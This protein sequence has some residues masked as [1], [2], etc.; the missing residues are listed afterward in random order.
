MIRLICV[1][2]LLGLS[3]AASEPVRS[4]RATAEWLAESPIV[5]PGQVLR[6]VVRLVID[7]QWHIYWRNPG[8]AG[9]PTSA[10]WTLPDGW[11]A[12]EFSHPVP[13]SF[14]TG[15]LA[16]YGYEGTALFPV[17]L[18]VPMGMKGETTLKATVSWLACQDDACVPGEAQLS[19]QVRA[20]HPSPTPVAPDIERAFADKPARAP[21]GMRLDVRSDGKDLAL[22]VTGNPPIDVSSATVYA[23]S[24]DTLDPA[25]IIR[26]QKSGDSWQA[27]VA[28]SPYATTPIAGLEL[29]FIPS[30]PAKAFVLSQ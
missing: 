7:P 1:G 29:L 4:G 15:E 14:L 10:K 26:F 13:K 5:Q 8:E 2:S 25:A 17:E 18:T 11:T 27:R 21:D 6:T 30:A 3:V 16:G 24:P 22:T 28:K 20:G 19:L 23:Q 9:M 12:G